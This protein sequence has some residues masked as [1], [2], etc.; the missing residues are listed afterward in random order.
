MGRSGMKLLF[1]LINK[2]IEDEPIKLPPL[3]L[4]LIVKESTGSVF[5]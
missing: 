1:D 5:D 4:K 2:K 3:E